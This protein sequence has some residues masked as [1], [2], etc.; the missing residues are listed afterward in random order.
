MRCWGL[1]GGVGENFPSTAT[2]FE[3][4]L[5]AVL[6]QQQLVEILSVVGHPV[7]SGFGCPLFGFLCSGWAGE[8][9]APC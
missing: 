4:P 7:A 6:W 9:V 5:F 3:A 8:V 1:L 2:D